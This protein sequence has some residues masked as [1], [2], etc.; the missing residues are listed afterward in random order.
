VIRSLLFSTFLA[1]PFYLRYKYFCL[2]GSTRHLFPLIVEDSLCRVINISVPSSMRMTPPCL[3]PYLQSVRA[4]VF[5]SF[6]FS[7]LFFSDTRCFQVPPPPR[8]G[9]RIYELVMIFLISLD[10]VLDGNCATL[11]DFLLPFFLPLLIVF[12]YACFRPLYAFTGASLSNLEPP[13]PT[14]HSTGC[15]PDP[16]KVS[17]LTDP[18]SRSAF[19]PLLL[20]FL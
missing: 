13:S 1:T 4:G 10:C 20:T 6:F 16:F 14:F 19:P 7:I 17:L 8:Y 2:A 11:P 5:S 18:L 15:F 3:K 9:E 12:P